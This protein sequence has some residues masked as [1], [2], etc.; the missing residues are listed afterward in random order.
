MTDLQLPVDAASFRAA[1]RLPA[2]SV[3][4][5]A[6]GRGEDR[7]GLTASAVCSLSDAP[8]MILVCINLNSFALPFIRNTGAF[9]ANFLT[10]TQ[11]HLAERFAGRTKVY[12]NDRFMGG[13]WQTL[14]TG[15]PVLSDAL[16]S[17]D[18]LLEHEYESATH[19]ILI[20]RVQSILHDDSARSLV[21][22]AGVFGV[23][24]QLAS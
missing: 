24:L 16:T 5:I 21:Y 10:E 13:N 6:T 14:S 18:C 12:G 20:G 8:P 7:H 2:T 19:A 1:M 22:S 3:T 23:P 9:S 17:F 4:V 15:V 11:A